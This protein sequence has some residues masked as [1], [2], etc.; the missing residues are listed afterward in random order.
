VVSTD[1]G[2]GG[3]DTI[4]GEEGSDILIGGADGDTI[5]GSLGDDLILGDS[6]ELLYTDGDLRTIRSTASGVGGN[7][8]ISGNEGDDIILG[9]AASDTIFAGAGTDL[10]FGDQG[11][12]LISGGNNEVVTCYNEDMPWYEG[13]TYTATFTQDDSA[14]ASDVIYGE[15]GGDYILG[16]QG[17]DVISGGSGEDIIYGGHNIAGGHDN[18]DIIDGGAGNDVIAGDNADIQRT[19][20]AVSTRFRAYQGT[21]L[22]LVT[23]FFQIDP[24]GVRLWNVVLY[25]HSHTPDS[26]TFGNDTIAGGADDDMIFGQLG[27]DTIHGDGQTTGQDHQLVALSEPIPESDIGGDDYV[28]GNGGNDTIYGGLGQDNLIGGN[29]SLF[30]LTTPDQ[31]PD[32]SDIIFGGNGD[33]AEEGHARDADMILG[34]NANIYRLIRANGTGGNQ[35]FRFG[36][37]NPAYSYSSNM[38]NIARAADLLD[39]TPGGANDD[40]GAADEIH[41]ESGDDF[42][43]GM[44]GGDVLFGEGQDDV[45][46]GGNGDDWISGGTGRNIICYDEGRIYPSSNGTTE[47]YFGIGFFTN[48]LNQYIYT[49]ESELKKTGKMTFFKL[50]GLDAFEY[51]TQYSAQTDGITYRGWGKTFLYSEP[52]NDEISETEALPEENSNPE[53]LDEDW[54]EN[55]TG[56]D[57]LDGDHDP[58]LPNAGDNNETSSVAN[59][60]RDLHYSYEDISDRGASRGVLFGII[61]GNRLFGWAGEFSSLIVPLAL[62][63]L[64]TELGPGASDFGIPLRDVRQQQGRPDQGCR[65][66]RGRR[67]ERRAVRR[68]G[69]GS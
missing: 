42:I 62:L 68:A 59:D 14:G 37:D 15:A 12:V 9:G 47:P 48:E 13:Y 28:E 51:V 16:Q 22:Y 8:T 61:G 38:I 17:S 63:G 39:Y 23:D 52:V 58:G 55:I 50:A 46:Y 54:T 43:H 18:G 34:D 64:A 57:D 21:A 31:R 67:A 20:A 10:I 35:L 69:P 4:Y 6:G 26:T 1:E 3:V 36:Y 45:L 25:D 5:E 24:N 33:M 32:G 44:V 30:G 56:R 40:I 7:D 11:E 19:D 41:G 27:D 2:T 49:I 60:A 65:Y 66:H 53:N 29:S